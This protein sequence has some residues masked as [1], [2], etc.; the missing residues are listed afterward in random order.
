MYC[1]GLAWRIL[2]ILCKHVKC[3][4]ELKP[5]SYL[6][7][8]SPTSIPTSFL[9]S[10]Q[11]PLVEA[12]SVAPHFIPRSKGDGWSASMVF[13]PQPTGL[14][15]LQ[16]QHWSPCSPDAQRNS[17]LLITYKVKVTLSRILLP[18]VLIFPF[19]VPFWAP[20][21]SWN[22]PFY[23]FPLESLLYIVKSYS[24][25]TPK[26]KGHLF[27]DSFPELSL[28]RGPLLSLR[29][30]LLLSSHLSYCAS[31]LCFSIILLSH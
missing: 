8:P 20:P 1:W 3:H 9:T 27:G 18:L 19:K 14:N 13:P 29:T 15:W 5:L 17:E 24:S 30:T 7:H 2:S 23:F 28:S 10:H 11:V 12:L 16:E 21:S 6:G 26:F 4:R 31:A 25:C 22:I